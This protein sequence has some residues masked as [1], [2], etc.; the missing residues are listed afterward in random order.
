M[1]AMTQLKEGAMILDIKAEGSRQNAPLEHSKMQTTICTQYWTE[2][3]WR[4]YTARLCRIREILYEFVF[5]MPPTAGLQARQHRKPFMQAHGSLVASMDRLENVLIQHLGG[6]ERVPGG[7]I[8][9]ARG[10]NGGVKERSDTAI[11]FVKG[12][13]KSSD[14]TF[15]CEQW[16]TWGDKAK[17]ATKLIG[18]AITEVRRAHGRE[19]KRHIRAL[20]NT[21]KY[22]LTGR[23]RLDD[24]VCVQH[25][26]W[27]NATRVFF[28]SRRS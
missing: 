18:D 2:K 12:N 24:L 17:E 5:E 13:A 20:M 6:A 21:D 10:R 7:A 14:A 27:P 26:E 23:A 28:G 11:C 25:P 9:F 15:S 1:Q 3:Q 4:A 16:M 19:V 22:L 8:A